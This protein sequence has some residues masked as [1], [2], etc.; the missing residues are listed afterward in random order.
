MLSFARW[1]TVGRQ[2]FNFSDFAD[3]GFS[4]HELC[5]TLRLGM[6]SAIV[7]T[8][9]VRTLTTAWDAATI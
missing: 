6:G 5:A 7:I 9:P 8:W 1:T 2:L 4:S 3:S